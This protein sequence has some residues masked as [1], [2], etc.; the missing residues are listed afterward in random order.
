MTLAQVD[1]LTKY[2]II[3]V[4]VVELTV[5]EKEVLRRGDVDRRSPDRFVATHL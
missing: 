5:G 3:P 4:C 1:L 2:H